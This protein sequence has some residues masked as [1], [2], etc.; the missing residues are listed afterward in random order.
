MRTHLGN[1]A[2]STQAWVE[3]CQTT[4]AA[5]CAN[6]CPQAGLEPSGTYFSKRIRVVQI[7]SREGRLAVLDD[8]AGSAELFARAALRAG[9][10]VGHVPLALKVMIFPQTPQEHR[11]CAS[12]KA[13]GTAPL[14]RLA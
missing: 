6:A 12:R 5:A 8:S 11:L 1:M 13:C 4:L 9:W 3:L 14:K 10:H 2:N 7:S